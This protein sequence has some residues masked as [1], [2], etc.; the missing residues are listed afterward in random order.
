MKKKTQDVF[1]EY[2]RSGGK[3]TLEKYGKDHFAKI[4]K[5]RHADKKKNKARS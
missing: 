1:K 4:A 2:G 3:K 5:K